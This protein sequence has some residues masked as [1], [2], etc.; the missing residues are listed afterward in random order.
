MD[1]YEKMTTLYYED[2]LQDPIK[3]VRRILKFLRVGPNEERLKCLSRHLEGPF[4]SAKK[5]R[6][7]FSIF[8]KTVINSAIKSV[9]RSLERKGH[10]PLPNYEL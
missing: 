8:E 4:K 10:P 7:P 5:I 9:E 1:K 2:L 6:D 3:E